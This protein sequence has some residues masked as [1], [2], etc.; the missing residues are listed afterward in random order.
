LKFS[1]IPF[2]LETPVDKERGYEWNLGQIR[3][4]SNK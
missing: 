3:A 1:R 4:L 2:I